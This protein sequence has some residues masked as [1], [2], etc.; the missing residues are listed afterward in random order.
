MSALT[1]LARPYAKAAFQLAEKDGALGQWDDMLTLASGVVGDERVSNLIESPHVSPQQARDLVA[2][3]GGENFDKR[4]G[5]YLSVLADNGRLA[6]LGDIAAI[7]SRLRQEAERRLEVRVVSAVALEAEQED[8]LKR[9]LSKRFDSDIELK[10]E[11]DKSVIG[12]AVIYAGDQ[13]ID[14][15]LLGRLKRLEQN[16]AS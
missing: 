7:Y 3:A 6:L 1:T 4:F 11:I 13:V 8:R 14:G 5:D 10:N 15:S 12:G 2:E 16:L 9:A